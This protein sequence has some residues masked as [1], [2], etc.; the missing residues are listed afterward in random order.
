MKVTTRK[1]KAFV[2]LDGDLTV[3]RA[4]DLKGALVTS[5]SKATEIEI[6]LAEV[7]Y[8]DLAC[9]QLMC[10]AHLT[11]FKEG[12]TLFLKDPSLPIFLEAKES[13]G[14]IYSKPCRSVST[15]DCFW[16]DG[17]KE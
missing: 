14:F 10:S 9:L 13:A 16:V 15:G 12:K 8:I 4:V 1:G 3:A 2:K 5:L 7:T 6:N 17:G 11:A